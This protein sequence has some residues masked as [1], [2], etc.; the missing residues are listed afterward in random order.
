M[1]IDHWTLIIWKW[2]APGTPQRIPTSFSAA[3]CGG[4][5]RFTSGK[6]ADL[7]RPKLTQT[8]PQS[9]IRNP[10]LCLRTIGLSRSSTGGGGDREVL[11]HPV[12]DH[13]EARRPGLIGLQHHDPRDAVLRQDRKSTRLNSSHP[14]ISYAVFC[15]KKK[16]IN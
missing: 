1:F 15:L 7:G 3:P 9:A 11:A 10:Q 14:S 16:K 6:P 12:R 5:T 2:N 4:L 8:N 13:G